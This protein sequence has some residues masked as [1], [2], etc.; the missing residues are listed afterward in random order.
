MLY[1]P[2]TST[3]LKTAFATLGSLF[4][5]FSY[6]I[7]AFGFLFP[8]VMLNLSDELG[9]RGASAMYAQRV[10]L[11]N[12]TGENL[13]IA[14]DRAILAS[15]HDRVIYLGARFFNYDGHQKIINHI[16]YVK[17]GYANDFEFPFI[18]NER[19]RLQRARITSLLRQGRDRDALDITHETL[20]NID[21]QQPS[22]AFFTVASNFQRSNITTA[23][24][25]ALESDFYRYFR[26]FEKEFLD[27]NPTGRARLIPERF[28]HEARLHFGTEEVDND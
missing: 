26:D 1:Y 8:G 7:A 28:L 15:R 27:T 19:D 25:V 23:Q 9:L 2:M 22:R 24:M 12:R 14:L 3:I 17:G 5:I 18:A 11:R 4:L 21:L 16:N 13:Y 6:G 10:Y 20:V